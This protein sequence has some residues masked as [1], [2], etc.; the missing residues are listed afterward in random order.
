MGGLETVFG[1]FLQTGG[2]DMFERRGSGGLERADG[3]RI[4]FQNRRRQ[5]DLTLS[6][7]RPVAR[8]HLIEHCA[9]G[10]DI[11]ARVRFFALDLL[12]RHVLNR[13]N[14][15]AGRGQR[16]ERSQWA[17]A[18]QRGCRRKR[19]RS[20]R[21]RR[22]L[23]AQRFCQAEVHQFGAARGQHDIPGLQVAMNNALAMRD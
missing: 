9:K 21:R 17:G 18:A 1:I 8:D 6:V 7:K 15:T 3:L 14:D 16:C 5:R 20:R 23:R 12:R 2:Q 10:K 13:A 19:R 22:A 4:F 11:A